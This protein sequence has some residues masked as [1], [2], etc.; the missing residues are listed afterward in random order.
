MGT[1]IL[2]VIVYHLLFPKAPNA[3]AKSQQLHL[4]FRT[5]QCYA[6][7]HPRSRIVNC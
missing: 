1:R 2:P 4:K 6:W 5:D 3:T 7:L